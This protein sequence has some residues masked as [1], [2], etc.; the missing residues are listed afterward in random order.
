MA[1]RFQSDVQENVTVSKMRSTAMS[2]L[3]EHR[4]PPARRA[5]LIRTLQSFAEK[6]C[7]TIEYPVD[8]APP[9]LS[10]NSSIPPEEVPFLLSIVKHTEIKRPIPP[11]FRTRAKTLVR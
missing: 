11:L 7:I 8:A 5:E 10:V 4:I 6:Y 1:S 2:L 3:S 9:S